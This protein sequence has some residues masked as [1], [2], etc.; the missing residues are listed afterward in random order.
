[1]SLPDH[2]YFDSVSPFEQ[3]RIARAATPQ[4][5]R[6]KLEEF[7]DRQSKEA[8]VASPKPPIAHWS[9]D[10]ETIDILLDERKPDIERARALILEVRREMDR[11]S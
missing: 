1:M 5:A 9:H 3:D 11:W 4:E 2:G 6:R 7:A 8:K 10:L